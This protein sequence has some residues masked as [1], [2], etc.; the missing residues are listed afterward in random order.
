MNAQEREAF[1][2]TLCAL[3]GL[4][5]SQDAKQLMAAIRFPKLLFRYRPVN[6]NSLEALRT[7]RLYF[8]SANYYDDPFDTFL[9]IDID[10]IHQEFLTAFQTRESTEAVTEGVK[11][12]LGGMLTEEQKAFFTADNVTKILSN[13]LVENFLSSALALRDEIKKDTWSICFSENGFN[14]V[15]W[16]KYADQHRG[17]VQIYDLEKK[18]N[19]LYGKQEKCQNCGI[20]NFGTPLYPIYYSNAPYNATNF[21]K[22]V[23]L[24]KIGEISDTT[25]PKYLYDSVGMV[26]GKEK[27]QR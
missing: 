21:A 22:F 4:D 26:H 18:E 25:I 23:M 1:W 20:K 2:K 6:L 9:H 24:N 17:F 14:E 5:L 15:L 7:N 13:G 10:S 19:Y 16:L 3:P 12:I 27:E 11:D 8:S